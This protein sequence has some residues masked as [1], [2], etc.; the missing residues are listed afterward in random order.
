MIDAIF[1]VVIILATS[2]AGIAWRRVDRA[3]ERVREIELLLAGKAKFVNEEI[4]DRKLRPINQ[5]LGRI[6]RWIEAQNGTIS[7]MAHSDDP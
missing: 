4:L 2:L 7:S 6:L 1:S 3:D 5:S